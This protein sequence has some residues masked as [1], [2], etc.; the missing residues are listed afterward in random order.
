[1]KVY[2]SIEKIPYRED[3][4]LTIGTFDGIHLGHR[5]IVDDLVRKAR[6]EGVRSVLVTFYPHPQTVVHAGEFPIGFLTPLDEKIAL[7]EGLGLDVLLVIPFS[8]EL[9]RT[10]PETFVGKILVQ[11]VGVCEF[12]IG[13]NHAFGRERK[14]GVKLLRE[15]GSR[16][17]FT[18]DVI[19]PVEIDGAVVSSTRIRH[20][21]L[22]GQVSRGNRLLGWNYR[23]EGVVK[24]GKKLG[25]TFGFPT[26]NIDVVGEKKLVPG[27]GVYAV[28]VHVDGNKFPGM[29]NIG[30]RPTLD[31]GCRGVEV[32][33]HD[34][35]DDLYSKKLKVE[36]IDRI[37][38]EK[39]F[40]S[41]N[42]LISQIELD[43]EK[44]LELLAK[45]FRKKKWG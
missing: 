23:L 14:G 16:Y 27:D 20:L 44:S 10:E 1:M 39:H 2:R 41:V 35:S 29:V 33:I 22:D 11:R 5:R 42:A 6:H 26:A 9:S 12:I 18:V 37:R 34:F 8:L 24:K 13:S 28:V 30:C 38:D 7:L 40:D 17:G 4:L 21:L 45:N 32:H 31:G 43:R 19:A 36:F 15:L 25:K 3:S